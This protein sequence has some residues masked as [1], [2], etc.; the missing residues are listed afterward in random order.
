LVE[1]TLF[2][3]EFALQFLKSR[4]SN[5]DVALN[6]QEALEKFS[7]NTYD[8][9]LMDIQMPIMDGYTCAQEIRKYNLAIPIIALTA[10]NTTEIIKMAKEKGMNDVVSKPFMPNDLINKINKFVNKKNY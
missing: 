5:V 4:G 7:N 6:G 3:I 10:S 1:D 8:I 2:N 9:I